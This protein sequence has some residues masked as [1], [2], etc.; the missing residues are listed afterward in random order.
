MT[1]VIAMCVVV[2][3]NSPMVRHRVMHI[4]QR[5]RVLQQSTAHRVINLNSDHDAALAPSGVELVPDGPRWIKLVRSGPPLH[6]N[7]SIPERTSGILPEK[8]KPTTGRQQASTCSPMD[9]VTPWG[10]KWWR[11][12]YRFRGREKMISLGIHPRV[13]LATARLHLADARGLLARGIDPSAE[14]RARL[15]AT[16]RTFEAVARDWLTGLE[17]PVPKGL[18]TQDTLKDAMRILERH[19]FP[20]LGARPIG[21]IQPHELLGVLKQI[22]IKG[23]RSTALRAKQ[24][25]SR[26]FPLLAARR[27]ISLPRVHH[28]HLEILEVADVPRRDRCPPG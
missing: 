28:R 25:C 2:A 18:V 23:L 22:A 1:M 4:D 27:L 12:R 21:L 17:V 9:R 26:V 7:P 10:T 13:N 24:R 15:A 20:Q 3:E 11:F 16:V 8:P 19:V 14:R 6:A 5:Q